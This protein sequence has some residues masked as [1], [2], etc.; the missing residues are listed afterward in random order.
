MRALDH[1]RNAERLAALAKYGLLGAP[2]VEAFDEITAFVSRL[3]QT[4][5]AVISLVDRERQCFVSE[6]G[7]GI[8][9]TPIEASVCAHAILQDGFFEVADLRADARFADNPLVT[10]GPRLR[11]Y[12]GAPLVGIGGVPIGMLCVM[13]RVKRELGAQRRRALRVLGRRVVR[14]L[15]LLRVAREALD[16]AG[17]LASAVAQRRETLAY[18][19]AH[20]R[21]PLT[22]IGMS[23]TLMAG[24][25]PSAA[26]RAAFGAQLTEA[27]AQMKDLVDALLA[28]APDRVRRR[29]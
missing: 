13:D 29:G 18:V 21:A 4:P 14:E 12:A 22:T 7:L 5:I 27:T 2:R 24:A 8:Q 19:T 6:Q 10:D 16:V 20:L 9:G 11:F 25:Q 15:D 17:Q 23:A 26:D 3:C 28:S 1:P